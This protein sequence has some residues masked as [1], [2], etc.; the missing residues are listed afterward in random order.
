MSM[1]RV[2]R[3]GAKVSG[4][5]NKFIDINKSEGKTNVVGPQANSSPGARG[6]GAKANPD[7]P[8]LPSKGAANPN[9]LKGGRGGKPAPPMP[10]TASDQNDPKPKAAPSRMRIF[11]K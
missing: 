4:P 6:G 1:A 5:G 7:H 2:L 9:S 3:K 8:K 11:S 10:T